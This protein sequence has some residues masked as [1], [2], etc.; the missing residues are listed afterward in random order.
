MKVFQ[1]A[2]VQMFMYT[3]LSPPSWKPPKKKKQDTK[4]HCK[5]FPSHP[6]ARLSEGTWTRPEPPERPSLQLGNRQGQCP[7]VPCV[8]RGVLM[9]TDSILLSHT[10]THTHAHGRPRSIITWPR[11]SGPRMKQH[12]TLA[13]VLI[14]TKTEEFATGVTTNLTSFSLLSRLNHSI[15]FPLLEK[16][17]TSYLNFFFCWLNDICCHF[18]SS[19]VSQTMTASTFQMEN[20]CILSALQTQANP[21]KDVYLVESRF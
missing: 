21:R 7:P 14:N 11:L 5:I 10:H 13:T 12:P 15:F 20:G 4:K 3:A 18:C 19:L 8:Q 17:Q 1:V 9:W 2:H 6:A 16:S